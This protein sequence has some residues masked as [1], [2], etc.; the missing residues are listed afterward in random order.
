MFQQL[1]GHHLQLVDVMDICKVAAKGTSQHSLPALV[2]LHWAGIPFGGQNLP[3]LH[4]AAQ[5][6]RELSPYLT[7]DA[8]HTGTMEWFENEL[9]LRNP[10]LIKNRE[11]A[12]MS[13]IIDV[14]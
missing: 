2:T 3:A 8:D 9:P 6:D 4:P 7:Q 12:T 14:Q 5:F 1:L 13:E 11:F 10:H